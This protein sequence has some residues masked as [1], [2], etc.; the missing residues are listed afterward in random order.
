MEAKEKNTSSDT[1]NRS[2]KNNLNPNGS[3][4]N[5]KDEPNKVK[6]SKDGMFE[7]KDKSPT[8]KTKLMKGKALKT[9]QPAKASIQRAQTILLTWIQEITRNR[10]KEE[11]NL[12]LIKRKK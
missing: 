9:E 2:M 10:P 12:N 1:A 11:I 6:N 3:K 7:N 5:Q 8:L 4:E